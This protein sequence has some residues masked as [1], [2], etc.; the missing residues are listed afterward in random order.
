MFSYER[1]AGHI[2]VALR[3]SISAMFESAPRTVDRAWR[4]LHFDRCGCIEVARSLGIMMRSEREAVPRLPEQ[5]SA[6]RGAL[7]SLLGRA[8]GSFEVTLRA[9]VSGLKLVAASFEAARKA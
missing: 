1:L 9:G 6:Q 7:T 8:S 4:S 5:R 2:D 3:L